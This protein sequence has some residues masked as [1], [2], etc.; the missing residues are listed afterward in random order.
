MPRCGLGAESELS[1]FQRGSL[2]F[3]LAN[4][5][6]VTDRTADPVEE[7][8]ADS[9]S[10]ALE[11]ALDTA[12]ADTA[13]LARAARRRRGVCIEII[14]LVSSLLR[15]GAKCLPLYTFPPMLE[16]ERVMI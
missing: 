2:G 1:M 16:G 5:T 10:A 9:L 8:I 12:G 3:V 15:V 13:S 7:A 6:V 11:L 4:E 14:V